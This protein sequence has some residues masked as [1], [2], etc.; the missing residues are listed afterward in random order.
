MGHRILLSVLNS[1]ELCAANEEQ[2]PVH[3]P[4]E[5]IFGPIRLL[6]DRH[7]E[8]LLRCNKFFV[9]RDRTTHLHPYTL[10]PISSQKGV[11]GRD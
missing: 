8:L 1:K 2:S 4:L 6:Q 7:Y 5:G 11:K 3:K 9:Q 10:V